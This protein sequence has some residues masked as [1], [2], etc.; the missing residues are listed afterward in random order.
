M[1]VGH[2]ATWSRR[3]RPLLGT[4]VEV[5]IPSGCSSEPACFDAAF[6]AICAVQ[7][8]L[9][10]FEPESDISRFHALGIGQSLPIQPATKAVLCAASA[11]QSASQGD[12]DISLG[13]APRGWL[14]DGNFLVKLDARTR[15]DVGGIAKGYAVDLAVQALLEQGCGAGWVNA[16][17]DLRVFGDVDLPI[18]LRDE[19][20]GG[21]RRFGDLRSGAFATSRF[22]RHSRCTLAHARRVQ[23]KESHISVAAPLCIWADALTKIVAVRGNI[24]DPLLAQFGA[25]SWLH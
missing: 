20:R 18:F 12:F 2:A 9:S 10:R 8:F 13:S 5:G 24:S 17:G 25:T 11:L 4:V 6:A 19:V 22:S 23:S 21:V 1:A 16:G 3:A 14:C 15:L 7:H